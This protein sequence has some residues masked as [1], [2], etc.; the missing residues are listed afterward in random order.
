[1][2]W[3]SLGAF[4]KRIEAILGRFGRVLRSFEEAL[5]YLGKDCFTLEGIFEAILHPYEISGDFQSVLEGCLLVCVL[6][7]LVD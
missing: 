2:F 7:L 6:Q 4:W 5:G 3:C 1:M